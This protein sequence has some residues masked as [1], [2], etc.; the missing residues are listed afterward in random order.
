MGVE[1]Y[2]LEQLVDFCLKYV[3]G[4]IS[5]HF[6]RVRIQYETVRAAVEPVRYQYIDAEKKRDIFIKEAQRAIQAET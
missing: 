5:L 2:M 3:D 4:H 6:D 1:D